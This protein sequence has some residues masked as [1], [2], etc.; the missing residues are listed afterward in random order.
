MEKII[1]IKDITKDSLKNMTILNLKEFATY[2]QIRNISNKNK[3]QL[4]DHIFDKIQ[5]KKYHNSVN[6]LV[7]TIID[8]IEN[9]KNNDI[10]H[11]V[12]QFI[13][14]FTNNEND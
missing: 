4:V 9:N 7:T 13:D 11:L 6:D 14:E 8:G 5:V 3:S 1:D 12:S 2:H 10:N